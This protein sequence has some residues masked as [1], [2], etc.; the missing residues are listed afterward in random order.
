LWSPGGGEE[1]RGKCGKNYPTR[2]NETEKFQSYRQTALEK[3]GGPF[4][5]MNPKGAKK[6]VT[7]SGRGKQ[8]QPGKG[9]SEL[10]AKGGLSLGST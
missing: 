5:A 7:G 6:S 2:E 3:I 1:V 9:E 4:W 8:K 10:R